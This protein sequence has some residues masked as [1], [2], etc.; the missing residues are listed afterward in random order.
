MNNC[1]GLIL[2]F[3]DVGICKSIVEII[4]Y[5]SKRFWLKT[6]QKDGVACNVKHEW[7]HTACNTFQSVLKQKVCS[8]VSEELMCTSVSGMHTVEL[9]FWITYLESKQKYNPITPSSPLPDPPFGPPSGSFVQWCSVMFTLQ[10]INFH[11]WIPS[12][13]SMDPC[14]PVASPFAMCRLSDAYE[15]TKGANKLFNK[16]TWIV[17]THSE[18]T[19]T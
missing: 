8:R 9:V 12:R 11:I 13:G 7:H 6:G 5:V 19:P 14:H 15:S 17:L 16:K 10:R 1:P 18:L 4:M 3:C 2:V